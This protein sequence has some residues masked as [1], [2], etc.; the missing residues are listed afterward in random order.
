MMS[1]LS[2]MGFQVGERF[3]TDGTGCFLLLN[4]YGGYCIEFCDVDWVVTL[5]GDKL[6][7]LSQVDLQRAV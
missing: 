2:G 3:A 7:D 1:H 5:G 6:L 4:C